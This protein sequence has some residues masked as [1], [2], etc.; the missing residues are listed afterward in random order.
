MSENKNS[1]NQAANGKY[2][3]RRER[4]RFM[5]SYRT[6]KSLENTENTLSKR[7]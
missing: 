7:N 6:K 5:I 3:K 2:V 1:L 4:V